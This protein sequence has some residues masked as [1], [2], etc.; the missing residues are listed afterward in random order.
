MLYLFPSFVQLFDD[1]ATN[2]DRP[3]LGQFFLLAIGSPL[4]FRLLLRRSLLIKQLSFN[5]MPRVGRKLAC[6]SISLQADYLL[7]L[8][9]ELPIKKSYQEH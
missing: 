9:L 7:I 6:P 8:G 4:S 2:M 5:L 1:T 3:D